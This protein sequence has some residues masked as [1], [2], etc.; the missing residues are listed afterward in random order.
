MLTPVKLKSP[1]DKEFCIRKERRA[2]AP[3]LSLTISTLLGTSYT[4]PTEA[5]AQEPALMG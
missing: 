2:S 1:T 3:V 4:G 5:L